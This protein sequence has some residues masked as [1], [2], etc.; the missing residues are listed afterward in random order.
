MSAGEGGPPQ[1]P[2]PGQ[3]RAYQPPPGAAKPADYKPPA[4][5]ARPAAPPTGSRV[6]SKTGEGQDVGS[7]A[8]AKT[9]VKS[10]GPFEFN[11][12]QDA[13][14]KDLAKNIR[15][16]SW[17]L[18]LLGIALAARQ[19]MP[20][21]QALRSGAWKAS[22]EPLAALLGA[23]IL[24]YCF[25]GLRMAGGAF[26]DIVDSDAQDVPLLVQAL[27]SLNRVFAALALLVIVI[28]GLVLVATALYVM[29]T[30]AK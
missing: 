7:W 8:Q 14:L 17:V 13:L 18:L 2:Q 21:L 29:T 26:S 24:L 10:S 22:L 30:T 25:V 15:T 3:R 28:G 12:E 20:F 5:A 4:S 11:F 16:V 23:G 6:L 9:G 19:A 27:R 1:R